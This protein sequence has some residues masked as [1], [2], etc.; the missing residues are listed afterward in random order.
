MRSGFE[1]NQKRKEKQA[2]FFS[3]GAHLLLLFES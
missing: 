3:L 1:Y 2:L